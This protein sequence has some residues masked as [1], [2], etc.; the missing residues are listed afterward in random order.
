MTYICSSMLFQVYFVLSIVA[1]FT[2]FYQ[3]ETVQQQ[4]VC[5]LSF[6]SA[7][8]RSPVDFRKLSRFLFLLNLAKSPC[9]STSPIWLSHTSCLKF[10]TCCPNL[11]TDMESSSDA[12]FPNNLKSPKSQAFWVITNFSMLVY[13]V[14]ST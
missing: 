11:F 3:K 2:K 7:S 9:S 14:P 12:I 13:I 4:R 10:F 6:S 1:Y 8:V 5:H